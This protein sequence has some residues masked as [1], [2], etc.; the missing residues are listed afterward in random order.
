MTEWL[1]WTELMS[2][3][4]IFSEGSLSYENY[5]SPQSLNTESKQRKL[6]SSRINCFLGA[7]EKTAHFYIYYIIKHLNSNLNCLMNWQILKKSCLSLHRHSI[8]SCK[9]RQE[10]LVRCQMKKMQQSEQ[11]LEIVLQNIHLPFSGFSSWRMSVSIY[12]WLQEQEKRLGTWLQNII[13]IY[14]CVCV[15]ISNTF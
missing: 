4:L 3:Y 8:L 11:F 7:G 6:Q 12:I 2:Y 14:V 1:N 9:W 5:D 13:H 15:C 10:N